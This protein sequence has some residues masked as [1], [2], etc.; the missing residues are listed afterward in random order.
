MSSA[1]DVIYKLRPVTFTWDRNSAP[2]LKDAPEARQCGL[3]AEEVAPLLPQIVGFDK[4]GSPL[5]INYG[6]LT[7]LL[8]N[9]I[10]KLN[11]RILAL[12]ALCQKG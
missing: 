3:I 9:E 8:V 11:T 5:N 1:S 6:D 10:Q 7:S 2:G 4:S 12:E